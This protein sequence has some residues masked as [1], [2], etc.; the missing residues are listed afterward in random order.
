MLQRIRTLAVQ[1]ANGTNTAEDRAALQQE[2][3]KLSAE[4]TSIAKQTTIRPMLLRM[5]LMHVA[6]FVILILLLRPLLLLKT[7]LS[8]KLLNQY[9]LMLTSAQLLL[10]DC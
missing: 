5:S 3:D 7:I 4:I 9:L 8:S 6:I 10:L 1:S 2:V